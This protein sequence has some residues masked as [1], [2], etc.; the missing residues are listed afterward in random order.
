[1]NRPPRERTPSSDEV[2]EALEARRQKRLSQIHTG[3]AVAGIKET[4]L[5]SPQQPVDVSIEIYQ[6]FF[7]IIY[8][9]I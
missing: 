7:L 2:A 9:Y 5:K 6:T 8:I 4:S 3:A 1:M